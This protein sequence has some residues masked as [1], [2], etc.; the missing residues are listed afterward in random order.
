MRKLNNF[1]FLQ[2]FGLVCFAICG[3]VV[4][5]LVDFLLFEMFRFGE[6]WQRTTAMAVALVSPFLG[7]YFL[8][9]YIAMKSFI[10]RQL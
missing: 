2:W 4:G 8:G 5:Y 1:E 7:A 9:A 10:Q 6:I 3:A